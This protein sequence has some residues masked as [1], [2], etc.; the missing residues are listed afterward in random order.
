MAGFPD[1]DR[2]YTEL[3]G[4]GV[5]VTGAANG[6]GKA[7]AHRFAAEG[8]VVVTVDIER[9]ALVAAAAEI[10]AA[11]GHAV[12][13]VVDLRNENEVR[14]MFA[15]A[16]QTVGAV[17]VVVANAALEPADDAPA[18][19]LD[20]AVWQRVIDTN[21]TGTFLTCKHAIAVLRAAPPGR[22]SLIVTV[23]PTGSRGLAPRQVAYSASKAGTIGLVRVLA[24]GHAADGIRVNGV[25]PGFTNTRAAD[26]VNADPEVLASLLATIP[27]HRAAEPHEIASMMTWLASGDAAYATGAIFTVDGG[28]TAI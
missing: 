28:M 2:R 11:G 4:A 16:V 9:E 1:H 25:M 17:S 26:A 21:L 10:A 27:L 13:L 6:I 19:L 8:A 24:A 3:D 12:P 20:L 22:R 7:T 23:S 14:A 5:L 15:E 18:D